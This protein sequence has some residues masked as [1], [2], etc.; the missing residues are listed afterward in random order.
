VEEHQ[1]A[2]SVRSDVKQGATFTI[3]LPLFQ[4]VFE[5]GPV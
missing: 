2:L 5:K 3:L 1:G 4:N